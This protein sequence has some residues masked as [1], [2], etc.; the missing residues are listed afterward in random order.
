MWSLTKKE[1][2]NSITILQKM[3]MRIINFSPS[4][5]NNMVFDNELLKFDDIIN[6][7]QLKLVFDFKNKKLPTE[8]LDL[9]KLNSDKIFISLA[10]FPKGY[11][12]PLKEKQLIL[13]LNLGWQFYG[14]ILLNIMKS[15]TLAKL[16]YF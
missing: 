11:L 10:M 12:H 14:I 8:L 13:G 4:H 15:T 2:L 5:T 7:E 6:V 9:F 1:N 3:C 16:E